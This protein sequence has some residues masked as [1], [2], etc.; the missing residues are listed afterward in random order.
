MVAGHRQTYEYRGNQPKGTLE[1]LDWHAGSPAVEILDP[2]LPILDCHHHLFGARSDRL[3]YRMEDMRRDVAS[4]HNIIGT[5]YV[6]A[7]ESGWRRGGP[8]ALRP[9]GEIE[10]IVQQTPEPQLDRCKTAAGIVGH[11]DLTLGSAVAE[12]LEA[13]KAA[14]LGR[15]RGIRY[16]VAWDG[17]TI[18]RVINTQPPPHLLTDPNFRQG[19]ACVAAAG[20]CFETWI[21]H[22]QIHELLSLADACPEVTIVICH[23]ATPI[24]I[25]EYRQCASATFEGWK[26]GIL[27]LSK[28]Q[29]LRVKLGGLGMPVFGFAFDDLLLPPGARQLADAWAPYLDTCIAAFGTERCM[30][31]SNFPVDKQSCS[32]AE[33]WNAYKLYSHGLSVDERANLFY[34]TACSTYQL[35]EMRAIGDNAMGC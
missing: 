17:G 34:R 16:R 1:L 3:F 22:T 30:F 32:Y 13:E 21:Y 35:K 7:Y 27:E 28:R 24:G 10:M 33:L 18:A 6:E 31:E 20:L 5:V 11:A 12:V 29:N 23:L 4:G 15:L 9:V 25:G 19:V 8:T 2:A 26:A 14:G